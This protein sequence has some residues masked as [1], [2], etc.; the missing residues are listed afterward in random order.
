MS[1]VH[2]ERQSAA[3]RTVR[4]RRLVDLGLQ[5]TA[6]ELQVHEDLAAGTCGRTCERLDEGRHWLERLREAN[7][8]ACRYPEPAFTQVLALRWY[9]NCV[10]GVV[11]G[12]PVAAAF[13]RASLA[14]VLPDR[15]QRTVRLHVLRVLPVRHS[16][17]I[18]QLLGGV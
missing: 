7:R 1:T 3:S 10:E 13:A 9:H 11:R 14:G 2:R 6:H 16:R 12:A 15:W 18:A 4:H 5:P 17:R 8:T